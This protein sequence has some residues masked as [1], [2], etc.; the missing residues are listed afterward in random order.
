MNWKK[1]IKKDRGSQKRTAEN[2]L[3]TDVKDV[4]GEL[5]NIKNDGFGFL[6]DASHQEIEEIS[7]ALGKVR[8]LL[9]KWL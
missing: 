9:Q 4:I 3:K 5:E 1:E 7:K 8:A 2:Y 6:V